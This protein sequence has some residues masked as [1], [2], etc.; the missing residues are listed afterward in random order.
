MSTTVV[1]NGTNYTIPDVGEEDWGQN[2]TDYL[3]ALA[4]IGSNSFIN[5][6]N[7]TT[8]PVTVVSGKTYLVNTSTAKTLTLPAAASN[9]FFLVRDISGNAATQN[10]T[11]ARAGTETIDGAA[12]NKT[13]KVNN[14]YW[15]FMSDGT[16]WWGLHLKDDYVDAV[17]PVTPAATS[18]SLTTRLGMFVYQALRLNVVGGN[19]YDAFSWL[20]SLDDT[21]TPADACVDLKTRLDQFAA[22]IKRITGKAAWITAPATTVEALNTAVGVN[23]PAGSIIM[24]GGAAAP[25]GWVLCDGTSYLQAGT[26]AA[27]FAAIG[28]T[29]GSDATHFNVPNLCGAFPKGAGSQT[30]GGVAYAG[31]LG[32]NTALANADKMQGHYHSFTGDGGPDVAGSGTVIFKVPSTGSLTNTN[33]VR[34]PSTDGTNGTPRTGTVTEPA[35]VVLNFIIKI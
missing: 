6:A 24:Y 25:T 3:V 23:T 9:A 33:M 2:V 4:V 12:A 7:V 32:P 21:A 35:N 29:Y 15:L 28:T 26:Y 8:T 34:L 30:V 20:T 16:N 27:L 17:T 1:L 5:F 11:I 13:L 10:I 31:T 14:G 22:A 18:V 19:W